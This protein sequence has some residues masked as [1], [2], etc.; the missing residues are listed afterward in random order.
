MGFSISHK[1]GFEK[2]SENGH[3]EE[4]TINKNK[5]S[6][7]LLTH[8]SIGNSKSDVSSA[9]EKDKNEEK[10]LPPINTDL[11][12]ESIMKGKNSLTSLECD[13]MRKR[14]EVERKRKAWIEKNRVIVHL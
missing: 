12:I 5:N 7:S 6:A 1:N 13:K 3:R 4:N 2:K 11:S 8:L 14:K 10:K 9:G